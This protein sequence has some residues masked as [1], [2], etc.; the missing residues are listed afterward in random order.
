MFMAPLLKRY[1][2]NRSFLNLASVRHSVSPSCVIS[3]PLIF[4]SVVTRV[5]ETAFLRALQ[6]QSPEIRDFTCAARI[7]IPT[8]EF[9]CALCGI[10][11]VKQI[12]NGICR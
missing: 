8:F 6:P 11:S 1:P 5:V 2:C 4:L 7:S 9:W 12:H 3:N 10:Y